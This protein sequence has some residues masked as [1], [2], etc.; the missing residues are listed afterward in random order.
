[1]P[2]VQLLGL[3]PQNSLLTTSFVSLL[4]SYLSYSGQLSFK[5]GCQYRLSPA[6]FAV[7]VVVC[8]FLFV[9]A[10]YGSIEGGLSG[11]E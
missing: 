1:M 6:S 7:D 3:N 11:E 4:V 10:T 5:T 9:V 8:L 2:L